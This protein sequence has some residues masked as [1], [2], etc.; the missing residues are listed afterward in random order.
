M[1]FEKHG[2][3]FVQEA[4]ERHILLG[5]VR[6][7]ETALW[8]LS[9]SQKTLMRKP[10]FGLGDM[11]SRLGYW[12]GE[13]REICLSRDL[14]LN[15]SWDAVREVLF[16]EMAHQ[17]ADQVWGAR[18]ESAH[19]P[20]FQKACHLLRA[21]PEA[22]GT[23]RP[24]DE[25]IL[26]E[27][28]RGQDK[29]MLRV[30]KLMALANSQ[31][32]HE[33]ESAMAKAHELIAKHNLDIL[34]HDGDRDF[35]SVFVGKP[36]LRHPREDYYLAALLQDFYFVHGIWVPAYAVERAKM[37]RVLE[38]SGTSQ[39]VRLAGYVHDFV[40]RYID[41]QWHEYN[42]DKNLNRYR[43]TDFAVG[44]IEGFCS[45]LRSQGRQKKKISRT[46]ALIKLEDPLLKQYVKHKYPHTVTSRAKVSRQDENVL[47]DGMSVGRK[48]VISKGITRKGNNRRLLIGNNKV[49]I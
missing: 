18:N 9:S 1:P 31:N 3:I 45:K 40:Q 7:W 11:K 27:A 16:H 23:Y 12:S 19:G 10:L 32:Q 38:I 26:N 46:L 6:E 34:A 49:K 29:L 41:S 20:K 14:V 17:F 28:R 48:L 47:N 37:G 25:R 42:K 13:K 39:N 21:N 8:V 35:V 30:K 44:T 36:A 24:L 22:S 33:A 4:L 15:H 2:K 43:K 5:L